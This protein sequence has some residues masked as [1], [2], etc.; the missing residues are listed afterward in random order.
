M[1]EDDHDE[2]ATKL[3]AL[4]IPLFIKKEDA[5]KLAVS[6]NITGFKYL[7]LSPKV[8]NSHHINE[9]CS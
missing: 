4:G 1:L 5:R 8:I 2:I 9:R 3:I 6:K 7:K